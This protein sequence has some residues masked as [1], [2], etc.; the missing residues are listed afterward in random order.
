VQDNVFD[1]IMLMLA[2]VGALGTVL[3]AWLLRGPVPA[4]HSA[5]NETRV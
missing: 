5:G 1:N 3:A 2:A 4:A